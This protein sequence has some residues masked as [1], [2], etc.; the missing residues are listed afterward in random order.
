MMNFS[1]SN[2]QQANSRSSVFSILANSLL[3]LMVA[4]SGHSRMKESGQN[5]CIS[6]SDSQKALDLVEKPSV[7]PTV[8]RRK[9]LKTKEDER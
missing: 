2:S 7:H 3:E 5:D 8:R 6:A 4:E 9:R 1:T